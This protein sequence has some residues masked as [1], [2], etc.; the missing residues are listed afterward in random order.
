M[1][2]QRFKLKILPGQVRHRYL[3]VSLSPPAEGAE[4]KQHEISPQDPLVSLPNKVSINRTSGRTRSKPVGFCIYCG[5]TELHP[6]SKTKLGDEHIVAE[7]LGGTLILEE[8]SCFECSKITGKT[9]GSILRTLLWAPRHQLGIRGKNRKRQILSYPLTTI[10]GGKDTVVSLPIGL[11]PTILFMVFL[12]PPRAIRT[13][14]IPDDVS[15]FWLH[16]FGDATPIFK[17]G[18]HIASPGLDTV[19]FAQMLAKIAHGFAVQQL[20]LAHFAPLLPSFVL[21]SFEKTEQ[22]TDCFNVVG[23]DPTIYA[24]SQS[25]HELG[26]EILSFGEKRLLIVSI[27]L[28]ANLGAPVYRVVTGEMGVTD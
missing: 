23:G 16:T 10:V 24:P 17:K 3:R 2:Q 13:S 12:A 27:R 22:H 25:L 15:G 6:D 26:W 19:R 1:V 8:A 9:E 4:Q 7:G 14:Y 18:A 5:S 28:F 20:G 11:H 21:R